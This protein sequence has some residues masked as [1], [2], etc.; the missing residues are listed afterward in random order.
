MKIMH[1]FLDVSDRVQ[2][3]CQWDDD[4]AY[5]L[6]PALAGYELERTSGIP[7]NNSDFASA[8]RAAVPIGFTF[9]GTY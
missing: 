5:I 1:I 6:T 7:A 4:L 2:L 3:S 8:V 9:K